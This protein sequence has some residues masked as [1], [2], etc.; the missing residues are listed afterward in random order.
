MNEAERRE[1]DAD[2]KPVRVLVVDDERP[3]R[4]AFRTILVDAGCPAETAGNGREALQILM[5]K[6]FDVL[7]VDLQMEEMNGTVFLQEALKIWPWLGVVI[8]SGFVTEEAAQRAAELGITRILCKPIDPDELVR[9][10]RAEA[11]RREQTHDDIPRGSALALMRDHLRLLA[12]LSEESIGTDTLISALADFSKT[13]QNML[14]S[15]LVGILVVEQERVLL[16]D[17]HVP[18]PRNV[19]AAVEQEMVSRYEALRGSSLDR[20]SLR[21]RVEGEVTPESGTDRPGSLLSVPLFQ[22]EEICGLLTLASVAPH[23]YQRDDVS[24]LYHAANHISAAFLALRKMQHLATRDHLTGLFNRMKLKEDLEQTWQAS[25]RYETPVGIVVADIDHFKVLNDTHG[26]SLG[27]E[28]LCELADMMSR[29]GRISDIMAR[30]GGDEFVA[31]LP[32]AEEADANAFATR[33][34]NATREHVFCKDTRRLRLTISLG[35]ATSSAPPIPTTGAELLARADRALYAAK[36]AGRNRIC[37]WPEHT[38]PAPTPTPAPARTHA[39]GSEGDRARIMVVDDEPGIRELVGLMLEDDGYSPETFASAADAIEAVRA[40]PGHYS[41]VLTDLAMPGQT[42][43]DLLHRVDELDPSL[44]K[45]IMTGYA[46]TDNAIEALREGAY[47]F[48]RKPFNQEQLAALIARAVEYRDLR[49]ERE[50]Y[51]LRLEEMVR[52]KSRELAATLQEIKDSYRFTLEALAAMLDAREHETGKHSSRTRELGLALAR[53]MGL[54]DDVLETIASGALLH[55]IGKISVPDAILL[56]PGR[57]ENEEW[58]QMK[59]HPEVGYS[60]LR[61]SPYLT[62]AGEIVRAHHERFDGQGYP[63]GLKGGEICIGARIFAVADAYDAMRSGRVYAR[64]VSPEEATE[65]IREGSAKQF[66]PQVVDAF[67]KCQ[68]EL[69]AIL[70]AN[71][72]G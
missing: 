32:R 3:I 24:L 38:P 43:I 44:V 11:K 13:V 21:R 42:G 19:L 41:V 36:R 9:H 46:T 66:D 50:R 67:L 22:G 23:S 20:T 71:S 59:N 65:E 28:V 34:L 53:H 1:T 64:P 4:T 58:E 7:I 72:A 33:L 29:A 49:L 17:I 15:D 25:L 31:I 18:V 70:A 2:D 35:I 45:V 60:I 27:D 39:T 6:D 55:D 69:E 63:R 47:D 61:A 30:Y 26:H 68:P 8:I 14:P 10:V 52:E 57:L 48:I 62:E 54:K 56:R 37:A 12:R 5:Q 51:R 16:L 40:R